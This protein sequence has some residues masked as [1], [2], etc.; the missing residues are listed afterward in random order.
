MS[1]AA[2]SQTSLGQRQLSV[3][4]EFLLSAKIVRNGASSIS[5]ALA[6]VCRVLWPGL[7]VSAGLSPVSRPH[8]L[9]ANQ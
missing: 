6:A 1:A 3:L 5:P 2:R 8:I 4:S 7:A 9:I